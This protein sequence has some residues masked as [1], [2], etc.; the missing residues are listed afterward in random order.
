MK[1]TIKNW[2]I[3]YIKLGDFKE[4]KKICEVT[5]L[6]HRSDEPYNDLLPIN[7]IMDKKLGREPE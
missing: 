6:I 7:G 1:S 2:M 3:H 5:N 4:I